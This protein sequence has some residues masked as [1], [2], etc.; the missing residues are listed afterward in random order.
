[1]P[2]DTRGVIMFNRGEKCTIR[3]IVALYALR[4]HYNGPITFYLEEPYPKE[5]DLACQEFGVDIVHNDVKDEYKT[6]IRKTEMF[7]NPPYDRTMWLDSDTVTVGPIDEMFDYLDDSDVSIPHFA[8]WWADGKTLTKRI[9]RFVGIA[10]QKYID[11]ALKRHPAVNTGILSFKKSERWTKFVTDWVQLAH[12]GSQQ[13]KPIFIA[14]EVAFQILYPSASEWGIKVNIAPMKFNVSIKHDPGT[15]DKRIIHAHGQKHVMDFNLCSIWKKE[16]EEMR[17]GNIANINSL[18]KYADKRLKI[19]L[20]KSEKKIEDVTIVTACDEYYVDILRET[21]PNWQKYK[22]I[23]SYPVIVFVHGIDLNDSRLDFLRLPNVQMIPWSM[24]N[25]DNHREEMLSAF[26]FGSAEH[27]KTDYWLKLDADSYATDDRPFID[28]SMKQYAFCGHKWRYSRPEHIKALDEW[29]K[30]HW[31][32]KLKR[33]KPMINEGDT[34][35]NRFYHNTKRTISFIQLH[36]LRFTKFCVSL[37]RERKLPAPTQDTFMFYVANRFDADT[38]GTKDFKKDYGFA[39]GRG[40]SGAE[41]IRSKILEV[42]EMNVSKNLLESNCDDLDDVNENDFDKK[43]EKESEV[44]I[45]VRPS[46]FSQKEGVHFKYVIE[47][48]Q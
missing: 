13:D 36:K 28:E 22:G 5:L 18:L 31:K 29:A 12:T 46:F 44:I 42:D 4:K 30:T 1:M 23:D 3:A 33:A 41:A 40:K 21:F 10:D 7:A 43:Q 14:D 24:E 11:E 27:V 17:D 2:E 20:D 35:K 25:A 39:Q 9:N 6:L 45:A 47:L 38:V 32:P 15:D 16:F 19:Y 34:V 26:V 37:L 48:A 8:G